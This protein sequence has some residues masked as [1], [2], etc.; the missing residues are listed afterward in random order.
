MDKEKL[1]G[2]LIII[3]ARKQNIIFDKNVNVLAN[4]I[5]S[6]KTSR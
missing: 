1:K 2:N 5:G 6:R 3:N 4:S